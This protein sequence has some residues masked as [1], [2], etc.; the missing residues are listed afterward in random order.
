MLGQFPVFDHPF[1]VQIFYTDDIIGRHQFVAHFV[2]PVHSGVLDL[3]VQPGNL[4]PLSFKR[5]TAFDFARQMLLS[6]FQGGSVS[7]RISM[8]LE[9]R[10]STAGDEILQT[11]VQST[12]GSGFLLRMVPLFAQKAHEIVASRCSGDSTV[13][14]PTADRTVHLNLDARFELRYVQLPCS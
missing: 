13:F 6:P 2:Q 4:S 7:L 5:A 1:Y 8:I 11:Q 12:G 14:E 10:S 9:F 3:V